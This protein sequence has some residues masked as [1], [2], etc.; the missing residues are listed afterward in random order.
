MILIKRKQSQGFSLVE[1]LVAMVVG[2]IVVS[3]AFS[4]HSASR[5]TQVKNEEQMDMVADAR[6]AIE[7]I[8]YDLRHAGM[9]GGTNK[10][11]LIECKSTDPACT[12]TSSGDAPPTAM[13]SGDCGVGWYY[14]L[15]QPVFATNNSNPYG[16]TC[17][18]AGEGYVANTDVLEIRYADSNVASALM[19]GQ[20]YV[21][22]NFMNGRV[23]VGATP[24]VLQAY[25]SSPLT[26]NHELHAYVYYVS[27]YTD[28]VGDGIPSL[29]R[30]ALV[31][32][33]SLQT[34]KLISGV[35]DMQ[36][37]FGVDTNADQIV[38]RY[39]HPDVV[40]ANNDWLNVYSA[41][42]M[43]L[44]R[45]DKQQLGINTAKTFQIPGSFHINGVAK[46]TFGG[47]DDFRYF[48]ISSVVDMKNFKQI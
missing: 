47:Q 21:R 30:V 4:L 33:P 7:M 19:P 23:F 27:N 35:V 45:T 11:G 39:D 46:T 36:V 24:P 1:L 41:K 5:K 22:S 16:S 17:I 8:A 2:L 37:Q 25:E 44:M 9:W 14:N 48:M 38:D 43:L 42:I 6:F 40:T 18:P 28:T 31:N 12:S 29:R 32:Q 34:Q 10:D 26:R 13:A 20:V 15:A 3:G